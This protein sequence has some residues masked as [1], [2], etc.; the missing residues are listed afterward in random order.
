MPCQVHQVEFVRV[1]LKTAQ[2]EKLAAVVGGFSVA[3]MHK[4]LTGDERI[5]MEPPRE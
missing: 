3:F 5:Y 4:P 2:V 1:P